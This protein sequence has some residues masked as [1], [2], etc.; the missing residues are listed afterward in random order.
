MLEENLLGINPIRLLS[1]A[2]IGIS[3]ADVCDP[4]IKRSF[5][6]QDRPLTG[7]TETAFRVV[8]RVLEVDLSTFLEG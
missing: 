1:G 3:I 6:K 4:V 2:S 7:S 8:A 5:F